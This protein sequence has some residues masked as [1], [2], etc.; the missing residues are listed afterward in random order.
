MIFDD[1]FSVA[2]HLFAVYHMAICMFSSLFGKRRYS[3]CT[4]IIHIIK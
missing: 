2:I 3:N 1:I 4:Q